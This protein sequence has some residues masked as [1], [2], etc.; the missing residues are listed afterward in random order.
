VLFELSAPAHPRS[1]HQR[2]ALAARASQ[3]SD[4]LAERNRR[5]RQVHG[6]LGRAVV[7]LMETD[8]MRHK[9]RWA[10]RRAG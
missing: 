1:S 3:V 4:R 2:P 5:L 9:D 10:G 6:Q 8:L 7:G